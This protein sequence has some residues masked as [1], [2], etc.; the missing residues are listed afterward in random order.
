MTTRSSIRILGKDTNARGDLF[1][2]L[3]SDV[4]LSLGYADVRLNVHKSGRE[5]DIEASHRTE[6]RYMIAECK[7]TKSPIGGDD[8]NKFVGVLDA[9]VRRRKSKRQE[10]TGYFISLSGFTETA[11]EQEKEFGGMRLVL[12]NGQQVI[13]ELINGRIISP[14][15][16]VTERAGRCAAAV[17]KDIVLELECEL[18]AHEI[19]WV[20]AI[21][22]SRNKQI[23]HFALI[24]ADGEPL[25][26]KLSE[27]IIKDD[28]NGRLSSLSYLLPPPEPDAIESLIPEA[29][30]KYFGYLL[31]EC[32][33]I[34]LEGL[35]ADQEV[36]VRQLNLENIFVPL[37]LDSSFVSGQ[38]P[39]L[40][41]EMQRRIPIGQLLA[42]HT[43]LAILAPPGGGKSTL[44]KRLAIAYAFPD[45]RNIADDHLPERSWFPLF[46]RCR[47]LGVQAK[48]PI[49]NI[50]QTIPVR[51]ELSEEF[52]KAFTLLISR[53]LRGGNVLLLVDGLDEITD[54]S[55]RIAFVNQLRT[56][57]AT[58]PPVSIILTS[59]EVGFRIVGGA[60][61]SHCDQY[62]LA[63]FN[64]EDIRRLTLA[65]HR[66]VVGDKPEVRSEAEKLVEAIC[67]SDRIRQLAKN[68]LLLTT[69]LLVKRW[70]GQLPNRRSVLYGKA[71]EVLLMT[72]NA[73]AH[74]PIDQDEAIPQL[75]FVAYTMIREGI[76]EISA[77]RLREILNLARKQM[78]E[79]LAY[80]QT[81]VGEFINRVEARS[82]I[83]ILSGHRIDDGILH[84]TY[85]FRH[86]TFQEYLAA[87][88]IVEGYY[89]DR[90]DTDT[91]LSLILPYLSNSNWKEVIPLAAVLAGRKVQ[92]LVEYLVNS[93]QQSRSNLSHPELLLAQCIIDEVQIPPNLLASAL[94]CI[95]KSESPVG[96]LTIPILRGKYGN[97]LLRLVGQK[98]INSSENGREIGNLF[99][100]LILD[101]MGWVNGQMI[102]PKLANQINNLLGQDD[103]TQKAAGLLA[104]MKIAQTLKLSNAWPVFTPEAKILFKEVVDNVAPYL[105]SNSLPLFFAAMWAL[106][107][108]G[109]I[110]AWLPSRR[111]EVIHKLYDI[112]DGSF[113]EE[114]REMASWALSSIPIFDR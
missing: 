67:R 102:N 107:H 44:I 91:F 103:Q 31:D 15:E 93:I 64:E 30:A 26:P 53:L 21:Y 106:G 27:I 75:A 8:I 14:L 58:Y 56:F 61:S 97:T 18:L 76:Q 52:S 59:R 113:P 86:L 41:T 7:A 16:R 10:V 37:F 29:Q 28:A 2:R 50:L 88:A 51:A 33:G 73:E 62:K 57:L 22:F 35:P 114:A 90:Q 74:Q 39:M 47:H 104:A 70:V 84:P 79:V 110:K 32:G 65:W 82:S 60:I 25:S 96:A 55:A 89:P 105:F 111:P 46:I 45:R 87:R 1:G 101:Q 92:P 43:R 17:A 72:W 4:F 24:H 109:R 81:S 6:P 5:V 77:K 112:R 80:A 68:P 36:S 12:L 66:E 63:D 40:S 9:E 42:E 34:Q 69:L 48:A 95:V 71:I 19:G 38:S 98:Y 23:T 83:L 78:P 54:D 108:L 100:I 20:W 49:R 85:E 3:A 13:T 94:E 99:S 11:L